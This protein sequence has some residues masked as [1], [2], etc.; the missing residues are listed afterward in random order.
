MRKNQ[1]LSWNWALRKVVGDFFFFHF[2]LVLAPKQNDLGGRSFAGVGTRAPLCILGTRRD[3]VK[4]V[5][6]SILVT[7]YG[8]SSF[9]AEFPRLSCCH[10]SF[11]R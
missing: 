7:I 3:T 5:D 4:R 6:R 1:F 11:I 2:S 10:L 9:I 8:D